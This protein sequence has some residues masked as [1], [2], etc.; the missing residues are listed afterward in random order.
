MER[1]LRSYLLPSLLYALLLEVM[2]AAAIL[3]WPDFEENIDAYGDI[4]PFESVRKM[5]ESISNTGVAAYVNLQHFYKACNVLG[6]AA[7]VFF[8]VGAVAGEAN[9]GTLELW[10]SRPVSRT[11]ML[12]ERYVVGAL[13]VTLP[14]FATSATIP[15][16]LEQV[17]EEMSLS[18]LMLSSVHQSLF[19]LVLYSLGFC[20]STVTSRPMPVALGLLFMTIFQFSI[21][22]V[23]EWTHYSWFR[24]ADLDDFQTILRTGHL[25]ASTCGPLA[26]ASALLLTTSLYL[27]HRRVP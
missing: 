26:A 13:A 20:L 25:D 24:L 7:A 22:L 27:F 10:L 16:L 18:G 6:T 17:G 5:V 12:L 1:T 15:Y 14:V 9:R 11:R 23:M 19:L 3:Y 2:I 21:Y 4:L 8:S